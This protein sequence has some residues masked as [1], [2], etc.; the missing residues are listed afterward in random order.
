MSPRF[1]RRSSWPAISQPA[2]EDD[3]L[4]TVGAFFV[5]WHAAP[6]A[7]RPLIISGY[8]PAWPDRFR[9]IS[10]SLRTSVG[11]DAL[12]IDHIGSTSVPG[13][14]AK[15]LI[16]IQIT[17]QQLDVTDEWP[18]ELLPGLVR[19]VGIRP[20]HIPAVA[21]S[22][23]AD[24]AKRYWSNSQ[25]LHVHVR[26][27]GRPNQRYPLLFR[28]YLRAD[29]SAAASYGALKKALATVALDDW[30][31]YYAVKDP[32]CDLILAGAEQWAERVGWSP[33]P[34]DA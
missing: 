5:P 33:Q 14:A 13:L 1:V 8:D 34:S 11:H 24:W 28:D 19:R 29:G 27:D 3:P 16:D 10:G 15:D 22:D 18:E 32:A 7:S 23:P 31:I 2:L 20:D 9:A 30:D 17:V 6:M 4:P 21:S 26:A 25:D 12:R